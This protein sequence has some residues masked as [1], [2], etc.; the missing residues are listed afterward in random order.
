MSSTDFEIHTGLDASILDRYDGFILDQFGVMHNGSN[1]LPGAP[2]AVRT[3]AET[4]QLVILSNSSSRSVDALAKLPKLGFEP[5]SFVAAVTSG[6]EASKYVRA[7]HSGQT[8]LF[9]TWK[10]PK[11]PSPMV[12]LES[13]GDISV[14]EDPAEADFVLLH[15]CE[16]LRGP[17]ADGEARETDL[18]DFLNTG[19]LDVVTPL[20]QKAVERKIPLVCANPDYI[21]VRPDGSQAHMPG[22]ISDHYA[23]LGGTVHAFGKPYREHFEACV[24][25]LG[26]PKDRIVHVGDSL[27]HDIQGANDT[28]IA[29][30]FVVGGIHCQELGCEQG[31]VPSKEALAAL[32]EKHKQTPTHV[33]PLLQL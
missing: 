5:S 24:A 19:S 1:G 12:F 31:Q 15:G 25:A 33:V 2:E 9:L 10:T 14:T 20:L 17:G 6:E 16:V 7:H 29:S 27:H 26:L 13:C 30:I 22:V 23:S 4:K 11:S 21:M 8:C 28:G 18:G 3:L 32:F